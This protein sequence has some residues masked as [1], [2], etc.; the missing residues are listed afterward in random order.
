M[1][2]ASGG[3]L[4]MDVASGS[5]DW[6]NGISATADNEVLVLGSVQSDSLLLRLTSAGALSTDFGRGGFVLLG[7]SSSVRGDIFERPGGYLLVARGNKLTRLTSSG[8]IDTTYGTSGVL[9]LSNPDSSTLTSILVQEDGS[10]VRAGRLNAGYP[11][12]ADVLVTRNLADGS[13]DR[14]FGTDGTV[15]TNLGGA[16]DCAAAGLDPNGK[17]VVAGYAYPSGAASAERNGLHRQVGTAFG[18][19]LIRYLCGP[20]VP[21]RPGLTR[22][23]PTSGKRGITVT[24]TGKAFTAR[25]GTSYVKF[26]T[27]KVAKYVSWSATRIKCRVPARARYGRL[28]IV[29]VTAGGTSNSKTFTVKR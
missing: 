24:I 18:M 7:G 12:Y 17:L 5:E 8:T 10:V 20:P 4:R 21:V 16:D 6:F 19:G 22:L 11:T 3:F 29:V 2:F 15:I 28:K 26:G 27:A 9:Y 13:V 14:S 1:S 25:R 23:S